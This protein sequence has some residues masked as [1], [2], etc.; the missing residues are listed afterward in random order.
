MADN[1]AKFLR[2]IDD[3][4]R[5]I[6]IDERAGEATGRPSTSPEREPMGYTGMEGLLNYVYY[7]TG[8]LTSSTRSATCC[9]SRSSRSAP[10]PAPTTTPA[11]PCPRPAAARP[12]TSSRPTAA[13]PGSARTSRGSTTASRAAALRPLRLPG[14]LDRPGALRPASELLD[15]SA[16]ACSRLGR[17]RPTRSRAAAPDGGTG[18]GGRR[19]RETGGGSERARALRAGELG[20]AGG[21][22]PARWPAIS[23]CPRRDPRPRQ[24]GP[25][26][27]RRRVPGNGSAIRRCASCDR[28]RAPRR[29][30]GPPRL[31]VRRTER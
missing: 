2:D 16:P 18:S 11:R 23:G 7:Q 6:E 3:P 26:G 21:D 28:A 13:S 24:D 20:D 19:P 31:P 14:R 10:G 25:K 30:R 17:R 15:A 9:T 1:L 12:R 4:G 5:A 8:A 22:D 27:E 29:D